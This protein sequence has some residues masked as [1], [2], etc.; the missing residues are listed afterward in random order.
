MTTRT[1]LAG[2]ATAVLLFGAVT[3]TSVWLVRRVSVSSVQDTSL[4]QTNFF[5][6]SDQQ[7]AAPA[8]STELAFQTE[9]NLENLDFTV[10]TEQFFQEP[11]YI[12]DQTGCAF[13]TRKGGSADQPTLEFVGSNVRTAGGNAP[14]VFASFAAAH[15]GGLERYYNIALLEQKRPLNV[16]D[17]QTELWRVAQQNNINPAFAS[18]LYSLFYGSLPNV[19]GTAEQSRLPRQDA[20][21]Q[22]TPSEVIAKIVMAQ[23]LFEG[24]TSGLGDALY[25]KLQPL[26]LTKGSKIV[27]YTAYSLFAP[28]V[29]MDMFPEATLFEK[30][31]QSEFI[32]SGFSYA[33]ITLSFDETPFALDTLYVADPL[34]EATITPRLAVCRGAKSYL[35]QEKDG[36]ENLSCSSAPFLEYGCNGLFIQLEQ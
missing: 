30:E 22:P 28:D 25:Q 3:A 10:L 6:S 27:Y 36:P 24:K 32:P 29:V 13:Y 14:Q 19:Y 12:A 35:C 23:R 4:D 5:G 16:Y 9:K 33:T 18:T 26:E 31:Y 15:Q 1:L 21:V 11:C 7:G 2:I 8:V 20:P 17:F 34:V